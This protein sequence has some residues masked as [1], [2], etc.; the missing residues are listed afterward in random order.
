VNI[1]LGDTSTFAK[2][3]S[4]NGIPWQ[5]KDIRPTLSGW[6]THGSYKSVCR[7]VRPPRESTR[8]RFR[9]RTKTCSHR[10]EAKNRTRP[11]TC[12]YNKLADIRNERTYV[13][14]VS[15]EYIVASLRSSLL[16]RTLLVAF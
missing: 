13:T 8:F 4:V 2:D 6:C 1:V 7:N 5:E 14:K 3:G 12:G 11:F 9:D 16:T 10:Q 15:T